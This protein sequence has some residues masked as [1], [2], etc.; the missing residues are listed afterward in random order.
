MFDLT[1]AREVAAEYRQRQD[2]ATEGPWESAMCKCQTEKNTYT[3][4]VLAPID[5]DA[6]SRDVVTAAVMLRRDTDFI[7]HA[8]NSDVAAQLEAAC[9]E[10]ER[11]QTALR[12]LAEVALKAYGGLDLLNAIR[13][14]REVLGMLGDDNA[15]PLLAL[16]YG[17]FLTLSPN[18]MSVSLTT[19]QWRKLLEVQNG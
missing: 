4:E 6:Q 10:V 2:A 11:L 9:A 14:A 18:D 15:C 12:N 3:H 5:F 16:F 1:K 17:G 13:A 7:A 8:R 19:D